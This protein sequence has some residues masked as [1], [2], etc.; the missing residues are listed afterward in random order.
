[1]AVDPRYRY[2]N[3]MR[4]IAW[5]VGYLRKVD[6]QYFVQQNN[7]IEQMLPLSVPNNFVMP[8]DRTPVEVACHVYAVRKDDEQN[9]YL[10]VIEVNRPSIRSMPPF[11]TWIRGKQAKDDFRPFLN[12]KEIKQEFVDGIDNNEDATE[13]EK[14]LAEWFQSARNR[15]DSRMGEASN[16]VFLAG[17]VGAARY[18][19]PNEH[20]THGYGEIYLRQHEDAEKSI[21]IR[22]YSPAAI[23]MLKGIRKGHP[24]A[25]QGQIRMKVLPDDEGQIRSRNLHVR[26]DEIFAVDPRKDFISDP[27]EWWASLFREG[28]KERRTNQS[29]AAAKPKED[30]KTAQEATSGHDPM[31]DL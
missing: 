11:A 24:V 9:C 10:R 5:L 6:D 17:Y 2:V 1:M 4:N 22:L 14:A 28:Q 29:A 3:S 18:V 16:K 8:A 30:Q 26:V 31:D 12:S 27:P 25:F 19:A 15:M 20:Q 23:Q 21:P 13:H 7:N